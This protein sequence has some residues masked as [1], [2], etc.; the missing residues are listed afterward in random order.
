MTTWR[1]SSHSGSSGTTD[2]VEVAGLTYG[3]G[4]RDSK[5]T[6]AGQLEISRKAFAGLLHR[7]KH[8]ENR[9]AV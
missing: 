6:D 4:L 3:I 8:Q 2:C 7:L 5:A 9:S 1:K